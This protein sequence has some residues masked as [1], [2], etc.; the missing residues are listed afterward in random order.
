MLRFPYSMI[1]ASAVSAACSVYEHDAMPRALARIS[2]YSEADLA[3]CVD[4]LGSLFRKAPT[5]S[6]TA[7]FKKYSTE[8]YFNVASNQA[9]PQRMDI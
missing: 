1:A 4:A 6:L 7:V 2:G 8:K 9:P 3:D 5:A